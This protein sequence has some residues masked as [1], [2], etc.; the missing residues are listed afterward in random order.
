MRGAF[1]PY[2]GENMIRGFLAASAALAL[3]G[4]GVPVLS[5]AHAEDTVVIKR[6]HDRDWPRW[7][8]RDR[9]EHRVYIER[10][11]DRWHRHRD[12]DRD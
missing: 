12:R 4:V 5:A 2:E 1:G 9:D 7:H 6:S 8:R 10:R 11:D 3:L